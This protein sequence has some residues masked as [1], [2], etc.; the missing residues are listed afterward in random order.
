MNVFFVQCIVQ[1]YLQW[2]Q[3][4]DYDPSCRLCG[5]N[6]AD[7]AN[8]QCV[9]LTCY[10]IMASCFLWSFYCIECYYTIIIVY[11]QLPFDI[12]STNWAEKTLFLVENDCLLENPLL[13]ICRLLDVFWFKMSQVQWQL[14]SY[15]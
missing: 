5:K 15:R 10:G 11:L 3:D 12:A 4:S 9:R 13:E 14:L 1:S 7:D 6:L 8:K 2:L